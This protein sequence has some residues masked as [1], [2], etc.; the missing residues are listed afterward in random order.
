VA[1]IDHPAQDIGTIRVAGTEV[2][3]CGKCLR[4][5]ID[6]TPKGGGFS[7]AFVELAR[8]AG[9]GREDGRRWTKKP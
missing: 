7:R 9:R 3:V 5:V 6:P 4:E 2:R 8:R 1:A